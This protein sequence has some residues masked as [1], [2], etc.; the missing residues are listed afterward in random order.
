ME[1]PVIKAFFSKIGFQK[2][3]FITGFCFAMIR[4]VNILFR[5][6]NSLLTSV[7]NLKMTKIFMNA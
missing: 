2:Y 3:N 5:V 4:I 1:L 6:T 7:W